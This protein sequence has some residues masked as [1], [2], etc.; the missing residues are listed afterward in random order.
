MNGQEN[1]MVKAL[2]GEL[3]KQVGAKVKGFLEERDG[4]RRKVQRLEEDL[5]KSRERLKVVTETTALESG[6]AA[7]QLGEGKNIEEKRRKIKDLQSERNDLLDWIPQV[8]DALT[9]AREAAKDSQTK[10]IQALKSHMAVA[11]LDHESR[12]GGLISQFMEAFEAWTGA[13]RALYQEF[14]VEIVAGTYDEIPRIQNEQFWR[15]IQAGG[16]RTAS[17]KAKTSVEETHG[18]GTVLQPKEK[19]DHDKAGED[20]RG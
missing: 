16:I 9:K 19:E 15:Y 4:Q 10:L 6:E 17:V 18:K 2:I 8:E 1:E 3:R 14:E 5:T 11:R 12:M 20:T 13:S 7:S